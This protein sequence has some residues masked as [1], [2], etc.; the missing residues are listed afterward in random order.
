MLDLANFVEKVEELVEKSKEIH[1][2]EYEGKTYAD[3]NLDVLSRNYVRC[4]D[5]CSLKQL[6]SFIKTTVANTKEIKLPLLVSAINENQV[7]LNSSLNNVLERQYIADV[8]AMSPNIQFEKYLS[9]EQF[10]IQLQTCFLDTDTRNQLMELVSSMVQ[11]NTVERQDDGISQTL[12]VRKSNG[13][14]SSVELTPIVRLT[15]IRTFFEVD[16]VESVYLLRSDSLGNL[17]LFEADGGMWR[18][19]AQRRITTYLEKELEDEI[20]DNEVV[21][22]G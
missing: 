20:I 2:L 16:Q 9:P 13:L 4:I 14:N 5:L 21:V 19:E 3:K 8:Q 12:V 1:T 18:A 11:T 15:P 22:L 10:I 17:A 7:R 6:V